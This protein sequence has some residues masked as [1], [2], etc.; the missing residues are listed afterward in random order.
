MKAADKVLFA[1]SPNQ[2]HLKSRQIFASGFIAGV[3]SRTC[4]SPLDII[5]V[6]IQTNQG[7]S[8]PQIAANLYKTGGIKAFWRGNSIAVFNQGPQTAIK[9]FVYEE[10]SKLIQSVTHKKISSTHRAIIGSIATIT[11]Q[12]IMFPCDFIRT[13]ITTCPALYHTP[14]QTAQKIIKEEGI[15]TLWT[16]VSSNVIGGIIYGGT[17]FF[18]SGGL[19]EIFAKRHEHHQGKLPAWQ[20]LLIGATAGTIAQ[21]VAYP[22][23]IV[24]K[25]LM[26]KD[27]LG[28]RMYTSPIQCFTQIYQ[29][30]G[31]RGFYKGIQLNFLKVIPYTAIQY[32]VNEEMKNTFIK[33]NE[34]S[35]RK[36]TH[37]KQSI[38]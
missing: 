18:I 12:S 29:K 28:N 9:Y 30:E 17:T 20:Y 2:N 23:D 35:N 25:K 34:Y 27:P 14:L 8:I 33:L 21:S 6:L 11:A 38:H 16:G 4:S 7:T 31:I 15:S 37:N 19:K 1:T 22:F 5:K 26:A 36:Q 10:I 24:K 32:F 3:I 13:R